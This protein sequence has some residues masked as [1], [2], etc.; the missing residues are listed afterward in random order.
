MIQN[1]AEIEHPCIEAEMEGGRK[2]KG[3]V[4]GRHHQIGGRE[5]WWPPKPGRLTARKG[6]GVCGDERIRSERP[7][8]ERRRN[9]GGAHAD[10]RRSDK[11]ED[12]SRT[13]PRG[14]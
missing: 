5:V 11:A 12:T 13:I 10:T 8:E 6:K 9:Q 3:A 7:S 4:G 1:R 2:G 14:S